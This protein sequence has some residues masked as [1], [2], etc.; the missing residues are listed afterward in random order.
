MTLVIAALMFTLSFDALRQLAIEIG[1][2]SS[3]AWMA[4]VAI[5]VAQAAATIGLVELGITGRHRSAGRYCRALAYVT[6][7]LSVAET[8]TTPTN[9]QSAT[10]PAL[11]R[12]RTWALFLNQPRSRPV[13]R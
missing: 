6:G 2:R 8:G 13:S 10:R 4:P 9:W 12:G 11:Q 7:F 5:D 1:V 3:R